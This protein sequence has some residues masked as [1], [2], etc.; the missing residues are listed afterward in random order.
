MAGW[1]R[2]K[3][4][5]FE[6]SFMEFLRYCKI[7]SKDTGADTILGDNLFDGQ[8]R[9]LNC[10]FDALENDVHKIYVL[11][12]RQLGLS[13]ISRALSVFYLGMHNGLPGSMVLDSDPNKQAAR[14]EVVTMIKG[15][16]AKLQF[17]RIK[18][19]GEGNRYGIT[20]SNESSIQLFS[21]GVKASKSAG[22]LGRSVGLAMSHMSEICSFVNEDGLEAFENS[23]S[24]VNPDRL[25]IYESTARGPNIWKDMWDEAVKDNH[26]A[27][28]FLGWWSKPTQIISKN[29][30]DFQKYGFAPPDERELRNIAEVWDKYGHRIT[31]EQ[32]AWVRRRMCPIIDE[33]D[34]APSN[35]EGDALRIQEQP[36]TSE[37][38][39]QMTG[40]TFFSP[41]ALTE[42]MNKN[43]QKPKS[44]YYFNTGLEFTDTRVYANP[45]NKRMIE[46]RVWEE[47]EYRDANYVVAVDPAFGS[48]DTNDRSAIQVLRCFADGVDQVAEYAWP[49]IGTRQLA[50]VVMSI[51]GWYAGDN[52]QVYFILELNG[53]GMSVKDEIDYLRLHLASGYQ[54][55]QVE[56]QGL[57]NVFRNVRNYVYS[58][59][60]AMTAGKAW[61]WKMTPGSGPS[62]KVRVMEGLR[63]YVSNGMLRIR[64][65]DVMQEM[66]SVRREGDTIETQGRKKDDRVVA[67]ALG[68]R[69][70]EERV[71]RAMSTG[72]RTR[73]AEAAKKS[74]S[75]IDQASLFQTNQLQSFF[76][77]KRRT[78]FQAQSLIRRASWRNR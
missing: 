2:Q 1:S 50:W 45:P 38:A 9:F 40:S 69:C 59:P 46:L 56:E 29:D 13:T 51:C 26:C 65:L 57:K 70:W 19:S 14:R 16:P 73:E 36:W 76:S 5:A 11:K 63:N 58:R 34:D 47:P 54:P 12:S 52:N 8:R 55:R 77:E 37:Q 42:Q 21:A 27:T 15:L 67:L 74:M 78:R 53:P 64:S 6:D 10:V 61:H 24:D 41:E 28:V 71:R 20:L 25:Y 44:L 7:N 4:R 75:I 17:P 66:E 39:F 32:L 18:G 22:T 43:V 31:E 3:R 23:L 49:L 68:I 48:N 60:D 62:G 33:A 30:P 35:Y 72:K